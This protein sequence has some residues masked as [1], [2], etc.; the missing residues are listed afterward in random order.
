MAE[1]GRDSL[2]N[3]PGTSLPTWGRNRAVTTEFVN[4]PIVP[5]EL[6]LGGGV[7]YYTLYQP[8]W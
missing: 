4:D 6:G 2:P 8:G 1:A 7:R 3:H 5:L